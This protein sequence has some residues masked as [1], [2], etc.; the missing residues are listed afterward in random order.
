ME[1][2]IAIKTVLALLLCA[3]LGEST[4]TLQGNGYSGLLVAIS[5][6]LPVPDSDDGTAFIDTL[7]V[8]KN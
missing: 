8:E 3:S 7:K 4:V 5:E 1:I 6:D 2:F